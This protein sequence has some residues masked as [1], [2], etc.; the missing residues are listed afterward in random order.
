MTKSHNWLKLKQEYLES[1]FETV[2]DYMRFKNMRPKSWLQQTSGWRKEKDAMKVA[3]V[4]KSKQQIINGEV[5]DIN[6]AKARQARLARFMQLKGV[7]TLK[8]FEPKSVEE[9]RRL[10]VSG[11]DAERKALGMD[12][13]R[14]ASFTQINIGPKTNIDRLLEGMDYEGVL[15]LIAELKQKRVGLAGETIN[16]DSET[17]IQEGETV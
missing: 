9:A 10:I 15:Q 16:V 14:S 7:T 12:Q 1:K 2:S 8:K 3:V 13:Q 11:L 6:E 17:E 4:E 5:H